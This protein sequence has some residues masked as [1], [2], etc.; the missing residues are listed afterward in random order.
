MAS[1]GWV[2]SKWVTSNWLPKSFQAFP[3]YDR[4]K[5]TADLIA[6][7]TVGFVALPLAMAFA[8]ASGVTPQA[9]LYCAIVAGFLISFLGGSTT[10]IG[11]RPGR[12]WWG[13]MGSWRGT[14]STRSSCARCWRGFCWSSWERRGWARW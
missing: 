13:S 9:G 2:P 1:N 3:T 12:L 6:G 4:H 14:V 11:G 7:V 10:Q 8:I 5:F